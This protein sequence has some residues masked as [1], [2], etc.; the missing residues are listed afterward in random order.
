MPDRQA[1]HLRLFKIL[2]ILAAEHR[3][4]VYPTEIAFQKEHYGTAPITAYQR[5]LENENV[6]VS[7]I[8]GSVNLLLRTK[9]F[10]TVMF[11]HYEALQQG[12]VRIEELRFW[13]PQA[14]VV[15][16]SI[17]VEF[18]RLEAKANITKRAEDIELAKTRKTLELATYNEADLVIAIS[19]ADK[20]ILQNAGVRAPIHVLPLIHAIPPLAE[21]NAAARGSLMFVGNFELDANVDGIRHFVR[22]TFPLVKSRIPEAR[23]TV[24]G[25]AAD[26][27]VK[28]LSCESVQVLG[29]VPDLAAVYRRNS[30]AIVPVRW[31]GGLKGKI[32]EAMSYG[33]PV[34]STTR[35][36]E[37]FNLQVDD[38]VLVGNSPEEF[39]N[40]ICR[41]ADDPILYNRIRSSA[42]R[43][44][45]NRFSEEAVACMLRELMVAIA[46]RQPR[47]IDPI[48]KLTKG[49]RVAW[50]RNLAWRLK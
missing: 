24:V 10:D 9:K 3:V 6:A 49:L 28:D 23:L 5:D 44:V 35:G 26:I 29:Y 27:Y 21:K 17:D 22:E 50:E 15:V 25:N 7:E 19:D 38:H 41:L 48:A 46:Q 8:V 34:I 31:G 13:Q 18:D 33:L 37:G 2:K 30:M 20:Q 43:F 40:A 47:S 1:G 16:D 32:V 11:E 42:W 4:D 39:A 12:Y 45:Y 14:R 36:I